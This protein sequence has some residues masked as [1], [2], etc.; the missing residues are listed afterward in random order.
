MSAT[1]INPQLP[2]MI[3]GLYSDDLSERSIQNVLDLA[4]DII[5]EHLDN[6]SVEQLAKVRAQAWHEGFGTGE[7][8]G[9]REVPLNPYAENPYRETA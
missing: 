8:S 9:A 2:V 3:R 1:Y 7:R 5:Q 4:A 6:C